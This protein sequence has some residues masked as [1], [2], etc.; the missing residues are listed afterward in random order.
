MF[1]IG[2]WPLPPCGQESPP[3]QPRLSTVLDQ[4]S[5]HL[6]FPR[7]CSPCPPAPPPPVLNIYHSS[8]RG[9]TS[10]AT[11]DHGPAPCGER[12]I[13]GAV[14]HRAP[15]RHP[16]A[17]SL[18]PRPWWHAQLAQAWRS[19]WRGVE[20]KP[21][22]SVSFLCGAS[23][24]QSCAPLT[25]F[26]PQRGVACGGGPANAGCRPPYGS[27]NIEMFGNIRPARV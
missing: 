23:G 10:T 27:P 2:P 20:C 7:T 22:S 18:N 4:V 13:C 11:F 3:L 25:T 17:L 12:H 21:S 5:S 24:R 19:S 1:H 6:G 16:Q 15:V 9:R 14:H 8:G 26:D